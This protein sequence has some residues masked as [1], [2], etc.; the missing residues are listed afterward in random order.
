MRYC[1]FLIISP[2]EYCVNNT[3]QSF[4]TAYADKKKPP[5]QGSQSHDYLGAAFKGNQ[6]LKNGAQ[7]SK[8]LFLWVAYFRA[9]R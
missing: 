1:I 2:H 8:D 9:V 7:N 4:F 5:R 6:F 3:L